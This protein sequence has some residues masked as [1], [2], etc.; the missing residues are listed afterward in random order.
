MTSN[1]LSS[2]TEPNSQRKNKGYS[3]LWWKKAYKFALH[4]FLNQGKLQFLLLVLSGAPGFEP[5]AGH[6]G[7]AAT[8]AAARAPGGPWSADR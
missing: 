1:P 4:Q 5:K 3:D 6:G 2:I 7:L 8:Q